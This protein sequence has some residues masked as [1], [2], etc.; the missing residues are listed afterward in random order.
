[1]N[2]IKTML[3]NGKY[4]INKGKLRGI[5]AVCV[6]F[7]SIKDIVTL[8]VDEHFIIEC[9]STHLNLKVDQS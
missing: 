1:M 9:S 4:I 7:D 3:I 8:R 6:G 2:D 5:S